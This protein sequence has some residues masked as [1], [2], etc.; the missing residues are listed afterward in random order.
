MT[1]II[2]LLGED[3]E[4]LLEMIESELRDRHFAPIVRLQVSSDMTADSR[5]GSIG[6]LVTWAKDWRK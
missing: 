5:N 6:G 1:D 3:A 2:S 4:D